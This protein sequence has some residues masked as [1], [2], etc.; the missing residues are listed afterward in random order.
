MTEVIVRATKVHPAELSIQTSNQE[1][2]LKV[3]TN[4]QFMTEIK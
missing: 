4:T 3:L 2:K 1:L